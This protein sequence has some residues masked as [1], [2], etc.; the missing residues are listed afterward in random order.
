MPLAAGEPVQRRV[1]GG[2]ARLKLG[3][4]PPPHADGDAP[5]RQG[6]AAVE[7]LA[8]LFEVGGNRIEPRVDGGLDG[9]I[10][11]ASLVGGRQGLPAAVVEWEVAGAEGPC[12]PGD[13]REPGHLHQ[14]G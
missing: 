9:E 6:D 4:R 11:E 1:G 7:D 14:L 13:S 3:D 5:G 12:V 2:E 8:E 10:V